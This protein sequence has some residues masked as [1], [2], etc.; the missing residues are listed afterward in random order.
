MVRVLSF[1]VPGWRGTAENTSAQLSSLPANTEAAAGPLLSAD[2]I[3]SIHM[4]A[5]HDWV[6]LLIQTGNFRP[7]LSPRHGLDAQQLVSLHTKTGLVWTE[8][9]GQMRVSVNMRLL[10]HL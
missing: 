4:C 8:L 1:C 6:G 9:R 10:F 3:S 2:L 5:A 7:F